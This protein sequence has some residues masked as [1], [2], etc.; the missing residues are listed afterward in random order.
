MLYYIDLCRVQASF[1]MVMAFLR[2]SI[3]SY[4]GV[5]EKIDQLRS[6]V[7][8]DQDQPVNSSTQQQDFFRTRSKYVS[9]IVIK[10]C[11]NKLLK[12][13]LN[14]FHENIPSYRIHRFNT[15]KRKAYDADII[16]KAF[17]DWKEGT[18][19]YEEIYNKT[20]REAFYIKQQ[21][22]LYLK[23][24][25]RYREA[26]QW[27]DQSLRESGGRIF[28]IKTSYAIILFDTNINEEDNQQI[29]KNLNNA[30]QMLIHCYNQDKRKAYHTEVFARYAIKYCEKY[31]N[32]T[33]KSK[34]YL[35]TANKWL[36]IE[37][38]RQTGITRNSRNLKEFENLRSRI[39]PLL[40]SSR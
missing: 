19:F 40:I 22:A 35:L 20:D 26:F 6:L 2:E 37:P 30:M 24:K 11:P 10:T 9:E 1:D 14:R 29:L 31:G 4:E 28:S 17:D 36:E 7:S 5:Y 15:F 13:V 23:R 8:L 3:D 34:E 39:Q 16:A 12:R 38:S 21:G 32:A 25:H 27:I 18:S 33:Q